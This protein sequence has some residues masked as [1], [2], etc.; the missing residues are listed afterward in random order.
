M[1]N[2]FDAM[3]HLLGDGVLLQEVDNAEVKDNVLCLSGRIGGLW[4]IV[5]GWVG[6]RRPR[7]GL[8]GLGK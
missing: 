3:L 2:G 6:F 5:R 7:L 1:G 4:D 8:L